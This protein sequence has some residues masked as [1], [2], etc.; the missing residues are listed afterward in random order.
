MF[1]VLVSPSV[2]SENSVLVDY[3]G[4][5]RQST[6]PLL[7]SWVL[8]EAVCTWNQYFH[9]SLPDSHITE[10]MVVWSIHRSSSRDSPG[11]QLSDH[12]RNCSLGISSVDYSRNHFWEASQ[13][14]TSLCLRTVLKE[15]NF[16]YEIPFTLT[17][18][19]GFCH[20]LLNFNCY[21]IWTYKPY[22]YVKSKSRS[23]IVFHSNGI[24]S[25]LLYIFLNHLYLSLAFPT[26]CVKIYMI[27][28][29]QLITELQPDK[30]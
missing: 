6:A 15:F 26:S 28:V 7:L 8:A 25:K 2:V 23:G 18:K 20:L 5:E 1:H 22:T 4:G 17:S 14:L 24:L 10:R 27:N 29:T 11:P 3:M 30:P 12:G 19:L 9:G 13:E 21:R 16:Q